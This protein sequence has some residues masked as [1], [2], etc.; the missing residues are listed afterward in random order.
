MNQVLRKL[1]F[2]TSCV[3]LVRGMLF[4]I[5]SETSDFVRR[6]F[7]SAVLNIKITYSQKRL[8]NDCVR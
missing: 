7:N 8:K 1:Q 2:R 3:E 4:L 5:G 6:L